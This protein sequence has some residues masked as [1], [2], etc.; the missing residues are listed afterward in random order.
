[1]AERHAARRRLARKRAA[2]MVAFR[3]LLANDPVS[4]A[5]VRASLDEFMVKL[6]EF[7][8]KWALKAAGVSGLDT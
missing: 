7:M 3:W 8:V 1:M 6:D 2:A 5:R 4:A